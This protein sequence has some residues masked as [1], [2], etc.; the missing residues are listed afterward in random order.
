[1]MVRKAREERRRL[2]MPLIGF[3]GLNLTGC[4]VKLAQQNYGEHFRVL[5]A[6]ADTF[7]PDAIFPLMD[8]S[9]EANA[10]G[11][12]TVFPK[13]ESATVAREE[14]M[15]EELLAAERVN[16][17]FDARLLGYVETMKLMSI[18]LPS[19]ILRGA[20]VTGP[21][22]LAALLMG[23]EEAA[24]AT[25]TRPQALHEVCSFAMSKIQQYVRLLIAAGAQMIC[26]LEPS[27]VMLGPG[28]FE[29]FSAIYVRRIHESCRLS[30]VS[31]VYHVCGNSMHLVKAMA[32]SGVDALSLDSAE[33]GV[34]LPSVAET[35][36]DQVVLIG[37]LNPTGS[38]LHGQPAELERDV[39]ILLE[40]MS[41]YSNFVLS[42]GCDLPQ[43]TPVRNIS[44]FMK[45]GRACV[46]G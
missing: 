26:V 30:E 2:V 23:A 4:S 13:E 46:A 41:G 21:Y 25:V 28:Q 10:I 38:I 24:T 3:P 42:T 35:L 43:E 8:L 11:R 37:N 19:N 44:A 39:E 16:I 34:D 17:S 33:A 14:F 32:G 15:P 40:K 18:G 45:A 9:V 12:Y 1:M 22:T 7:H 27:A 5:K 6:V 20:Y 31:T 36:R 29:E